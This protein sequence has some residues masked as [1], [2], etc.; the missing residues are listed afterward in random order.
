M[1]T[2]A[3]AEAEIIKETR[4]WSSALE[5][6]SKIV[7]ALLGAFYVLGILTVNAYV[8][9]FGFTQYSLVE[10]QYLF[11]GAW[12][13]AFIAVSC[14]PILA[15]GGVAP[16]KGEEKSGKT[17]QGILAILILAIPLVLWYQFLKFLPQEAKLMPL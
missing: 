14:F 13:A 16:K 9:G 3:N 1:A 15:A 4:S 11:A 6:G 5:V 7:A 12:A 10:S 8:S 17:G 2:A